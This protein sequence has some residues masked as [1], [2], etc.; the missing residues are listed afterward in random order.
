M[1][2]SRR[3]KIHF[4]KKNIMQIRFFKEI[5]EINKTRIALCKENTTNKF[6]SLLS[7]LAP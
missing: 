6:F 1:I 4:G 3:E 2:T 7:F 5:E